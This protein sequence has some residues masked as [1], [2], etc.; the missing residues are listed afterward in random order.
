[1]SVCCGFSPISH[2]LNYGVTEKADVLALRFLPD[3]P[4]VKLGVYS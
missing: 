3:L 2:R 1:M 4:S